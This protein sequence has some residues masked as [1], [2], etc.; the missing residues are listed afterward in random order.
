MEH[1]DVTTPAAADQPVKEE[2]PWAVCE[3]CGSTELV[4][5][6]VIVGDGN[7]AYEQYQRIACLD[8]GQD[9]GV[10]HNGAGKMLLRHREIPSAPVPVTQDVLNLGYQ[11]TPAV[12]EYENVNLL[13]ACIAIMTAPADCGLAA[14]NTGD[15]IGQIRWRLEARRQEMRLCPN[16]TAAEMIANAY[17]L[18]APAPV[19]VERIAEEI[20]RLATLSSVQ[21]FVPFDHHGASAAVAS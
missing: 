18:Q 8:C 4:A 6:N 17:T 21:T 7:S 19:P 2:G 1:N 15:W 9:N 5:R 13:E 11:L 20:A 12:I 3:S 16:H 10:P 14:L